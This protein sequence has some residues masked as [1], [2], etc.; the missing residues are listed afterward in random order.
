MPVRRRAALAQRPLANNGDL[1]AQPVRPVTD[2]D[3]SDIRQPD[4]QRAHARRI[5]F[6]RGSRT[7]RRRT[8]SHSQSPCTAPGTYTNTVIPPS[9]PKRQIESNRRTCDLLI[10]LA[11]SLFVASLS[12]AEESAPVADLVTFL[13]KRRRP[14]S[15]SER[16]TMRNGPRYPY[17]GATGVFDYI[18]EFLFDEVTLLVGEDG[19]VANEDG[20]PVTQMAWG[21]YWVN[22]HAHVLTGRSVS[23]ELAF[24]ALRRADVRPLITG[25]VQAKLSMG[26]LKRLEIPMPV[27]RAALDAQILE[28]LGAWRSRHDE[29]RALAT[30]RDALLPELLSGRL[31]VP[32]AEQAVGGVV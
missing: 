16:D 20:T 10:E 32:E 22:N 18:D 9:D 24:I 11:D 1:D 30:L 27:E 21:R 4:K 14:L 15:A 8:P 2:P 5:D 3:H 26:N 17:F 13:N 25:A 28:L 23:T 29:S 6:H 31:R 7:R 12:V 19:S